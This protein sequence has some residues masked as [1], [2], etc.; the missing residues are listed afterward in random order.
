MSSTPASPEPLVSVIVPSYNQG[1][2]L[3]A[4]L[5]SIFRQDYRPLEVIV[6][7]GASTD[8]TVSILERAEGEHPELRW[9]SE[10][11]DGPEDAINKGLA[12]AGGEIA[13]IQSSDDIYFPGTVRAAVDGFARHP[14]AAIIYGDA[15]AID[16]DGNHVSGPTRYL[17]WTLERYLC[18]STF[19][20]QSSAFFRPALAREVG[21]V[22]NR[23]FVFDIDLWLRMMFRGEPVKI[24]GV[25]SAYRHHDDQRDNQ[26]GEIVGS[27]RRM[28]AESPELARSAWHVRVAGWAG[29]RMLTQHYN[30]SSNPRYAT[31]QM[32]LAILAYP[33]SVRAIVKPEKLIPA[34]PT[35]RGLIRRLG[36][37]SPGRAGD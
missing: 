22:R 32:W 19:I 16:A 31:V 30:P 29:G 17:P 21:G 37:L 28:I 35:V 18:G 27:F 25:L 1:K 26:A 2:F 4:T 33:P 8:D 12:M 14:N 13:A 36:R 9:V 5:D 3:Q 6:V 10:P 23:Y 24:D 15:R 20:P 11:D 34:R 7:D